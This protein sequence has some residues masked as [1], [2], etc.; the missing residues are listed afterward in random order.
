ME[1]FA[2]ATRRD[3]EGFAARLAAV[4]PHPGAL[5]AL[6]LGANGQRGDIH[7]DPQPALGEPMVWGLAIALEVIPRD[8]AESVDRLRGTGL[9]GA[10]N[11]RLLRTA[12]AP[13]RPLHRRIEA[14]GAIALGDGLGATEDP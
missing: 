4:A 12:R 1:D 8:A 6:G 13:K 3:P 5:T 2:V 10:R 14:D 7:I 11:R 9:Q